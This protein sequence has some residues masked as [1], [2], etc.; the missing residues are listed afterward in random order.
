V[1]LDHAD[2]LGATVAE[3]AREKAGI[4]KTGATGV[5][6]MQPPD[7]LE[8]IKARAREAVAP[9]SVW[10]EDFEAFEQN[11]RLVFQSAERLLDAPSAVAGTHAAPRRRPARSPY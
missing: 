4:L 1:S 10:G 9:L 6:S 5:I 8:V 7:A 2:K 11:S 3:I